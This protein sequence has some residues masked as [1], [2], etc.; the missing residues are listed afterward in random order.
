MSNQLSDALASIKFEA[1]QWQFIDF[2]INIPAGSFGSDAINPHTQYSNPLAVLDKQGT[3]ALGASFTLGEGNQMICEA[4]DFI[5]RQLDGATVGDLICSEKGFFET[6]ANPL[7]LRW[8]SPNS[9]V[10]HMAAGLIANTLLD[11]AAKA[12]GMPAWEYLAKLPSDFLLDLVQDRHLSSRYSKSE[13]KKILDNGLE[14]IDERCLQL[15]DTGLPVYYTTWIGHDAES[16]ASQIRKQHTDR[17]IRQFKIKIG[18]DIAGDIRKI[19]AIKSQI[20]NDILLCVDA[21]QTLS[22]DQ[23][24]DWMDLLSENGIVWLEEPFAPDNTTLFSELLAKKSE[25]SWSCEIVTGENC[26]NHYT[27]AALMKSGID[28][29]QSDP[30]RM[31]G[32]LDTVITSCIGKIENCPITPHAGGSSLDEQSP[33]IQ[34]FNLARVQKHIDPMSTLTENVGFCSKYF[35]APTIVENGIAKTPIEPGL[36]IGLAKEASISIRNYKEGIS[37]LE[38]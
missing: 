23:A 3:T 31:M 29:F 32:L 15:R 9:G 35:A 4:A 16:I 28:R 33:H 18:S 1:L 20:P 26:P 17:G 2:R 36:M 34:L 13:I 25:R 10:P 12:C 22:L 24:V 5:V 7:Q 8:L 37:W 21:N 27:A 38:L 30:C 6:L 14:G 19:Q 11:A